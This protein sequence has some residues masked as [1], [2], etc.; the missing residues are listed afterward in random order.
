MAKKAAAKK[1][2]RRDSRDSRALRKH[3]DR[4][5]G[6]YN[7]YSGHGTARD[8]RTATNHNAAV[9]TEQSAISMWRG[10]DIMARIIEKMPS[11]AVRRGIALKVAD[12]GKRK[13]GSGK[14]LAE[15]VM[16]ELERLKL[17]EKVKLAGQYERAYGGSAIFPVISGAVGELHEPLEGYLTGIVRIEALHVL[18]AR[19][20]RPASWYTDINHPKFRQPETYRL[21][22]LAGASGTS[23]DSEIIHESRLIILPG[24]KVSNALQPG[25]RPGWGDSIV[26]RCLEVVADY[27]LAW[28]SAATLLHEFATGVVKMDQLTEL[29]SSKGGR[30]VVADKLDL[31]EMVKSTINA[32]VI[33]KND[34]YSRQS[35]PVSGLEGL[36]VQLAQRL[37]AAA[38][39]P[40]TILMG[41]SPAGMNATGESDIRGWYDRV[42]SLQSIYTAIIE[43]I[44]G[45]VMLQNDG[46]TGGVEP[47]T[48]SVEWVP[49]WQ[50]SEKEVA[51]TRKIVAD[52]DK[53][54]YDMG[55]AKGSTIAKSRWGGDT[56]SADMHFDAGELEGL[57]EQ[58]N[59]ANTDPANMSD[60]D[61]EALGV[62]VE[63]YRAAQEA[64]AAGAAAAP[65]SDLT[66][67]P[68]APAGAPVVEQ[69]NIQ[70]TVLNGAQ[71]SSLVAVIT[72]TVNG[73][74]SRESAKQIIV[75]AYQVSLEQAEL[76]LGPEDFEP[77]DNTPPAL[78]PFAGKN[79][80]PGAG[81]PPIGEDGKPAEDDEEKP[82]DEGKQ[83][84]L[85]LE[86]AGE[87]PAEVAEKPAP[88]KK[89]KGKKGPP[90][91]EKPAE[92][93]EED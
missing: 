85:P 41:M 84:E 53:V 3:A 59:L 23:I 55:A 78:Q 25:Q 22:P 42:S 69:V 46:P 63:A 47:D 7:E 13:G 60:E 81:K 35:T 62:D 91:E 72:S 37:A 20:L 80:P 31:I 87:K 15:Q 58:D 74:I 21:W 52:T 89:A 61:L 83:A 71:V 88:K 34:D 9:V 39:M 43:W 8:R 48:W 11:E 65:S 14:E 24:V 18:E 29:L 92:D 73:E 49:L 45:L 1:V 64:K 93:V 17:L 28:G 27:G 70:A 40:V 30:R 50:P 66:V 10:D 86:Q 56:Y 79:P 82:A 51:E 32:R 36:L 26:M 90:P 19:E 54:Y 77:V 75:L 44:V 68:N 67:D 38:D 57:A 12:K 2:T 76:L 4:R 33:D 6:F 16:S 5:D